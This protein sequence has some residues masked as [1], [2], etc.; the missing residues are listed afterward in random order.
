MGIKDLLLNDTFKYKRTDINHG[1]YIDM[2]HEISSVPL[3][4]NIDGDVNY[5]KETTVTINKDDILIIVDMQNDFMDYENSSGEN[6][7]KWFA[8]DIDETKAGAFGVAQ[9]TGM[10]LD[11]FLKVIQMFKEKEAMIIATKDYHPASHCSF[12]SKKNPEGYPPHCEWGEP[13][14]KI[15]EPI[16]NEI[17]NHPETR[18]VYKGFDVDTDSFSGL[19]YAKYTNE[20]SK[21]CGC[22]DN[23]EGGC[24]STW[25]G[26]FE[27]EGLPK[28][29]NP[30][31]MKTYI[32]ACKENGNFN[33]DDEDNPKTGCEMTRLDKILETQQDIK[34]GVKLN[35]FIVGLAGDICVLDTA[36]NAANAGYNVYIIDDL[37]RIAFVPIEYGGKG[38]VNTPLD[39]L[40]KIKDKDITLIE[41]SQISGTGVGPVPG[42]GGTSFGKRRKSR[43]SRKSRKKSKRKSLKKSKRK[44]LKKSKRK[45]R[46]SRKKS[47]RK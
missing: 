28:D 27:I 6:K 44:S 29:A 45:S 36:I 9:S 26:S 32:D 3:V 12:I 14:A 42:V 13:G 31:D 11:N 21:V 30:P 37:I 25:T 16:L 41:S 23:G 19:Q 22:G 38:Y 33:N 47:K 4:G 15:V 34:N 1:N 39:F 8:G 7:K 46:K 17:K 18:I 35:I 10:D 2:L 43:K 5:D 40:D 20:I 24:S